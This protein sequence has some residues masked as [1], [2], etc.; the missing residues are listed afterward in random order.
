MTHLSV[1]GLQWGDE[2]KGKVVDYLSKYLKVVV[3][4]Q[5]G[6]NA[7]HTLVIGEKIYKLNLLPS[8]IV[9]QGV[10]SIID[11][12]VVID[13]CAL[14]DEIQNIEFDIT[15]KDLMI[16][17][18]CHLIFDV[19]RKLDAVYEE[20]RTNA[21]IGTTNK[22]IGPCYEDKVARRGIR[23]CDVYDD[24]L[25]DFIELFLK[26][27]NTIRKA[28]NI[29]E[30]N[31]Q[32]MAD[33]IRHTMQKLN[34]YIVN[35]KRI[36]DVFARNTVLFEGAQ[37]CLL[38]VNYGTYPFVTSSSTVMNNSKGDDNFVLGVA[39]AYVT[40]VGNGVF[41]TEQYNNIGLHLQKIGKEIG[42]VSGRIRRC[43]W[44]DLV[45]LKHAARI[46]GTH[47]IVLTKLD[48][49]D[50]MDEIKIC[51]HYMYDG[52][53]CDYLPSSLGAQ[54]NLEPIYETLP[55]W[56]ESTH[57]LTNLEQL[58]E[59]AISYINRIEELLGLPIVMVS[60]GADREDIVILI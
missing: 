11:Q 54:S 44:L 36:N 35:R 42:T 13:P 7:G 6:N 12:E 59:N 50:G 2:G 28:L 41:P 14:I 33:D 32:E 19:H 4:F 31:A 60:T 43:G 3:R 51:T 39:K 53:H 21:K 17:E 5:G 15:E 8:G 10:L 55:G 27:H 45:L 29:T 30:I 25:L 49:L 56:S 9:R 1:I 37:G 52:Q 38:D 20:W 24:N 46:S 18:D 57:K 47:G 16:S 34:P 58:P 23:I 22:G 40:R 26:Y 48:I